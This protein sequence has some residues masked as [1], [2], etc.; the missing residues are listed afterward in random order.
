MT[1]PQVQYEKILARFFRFIAIA[2][3]HRR[4]LFWPN[5]ILQNETPKQLFQTNSVSLIPNMKSVFFHRPK[6]N[7]QSVE[8]Y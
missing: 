5:F 1:I 6:V 7:K 3:R 2:K 8:N 4:L